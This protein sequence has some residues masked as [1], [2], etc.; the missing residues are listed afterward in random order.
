MVKKVFFLCLGIAAAIKCQAV[1]FENIGTLEEGSTDGCLTV[2][3]VVR[4]IPADTKELKIS[5]TIGDASAEI[6]A[7]RL[8]QKCHCLQVIDLSSPHLTEVWMFQNIVLQPQFQH[9]IVQN[10]HVYGCAVEDLRKKCAAQQDMDPETAKN[11]ARKVIWLFED[12]LEGARKRLFISPT[13][14]RR[15]KEYYTSS[16]ALTP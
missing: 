6:L 5:G 14:F 3:D 10:A 1:H 11:A 9:L 4:E 16:A 15:H 13:S 2:H 12:A 8:E 7:R